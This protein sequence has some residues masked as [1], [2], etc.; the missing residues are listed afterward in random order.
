MQYVGQTRKQLRH[1][2][3]GH[4][5]PNGVLAVHKH[6]MYGDHSFAHFTVQPLE[7]IPDELDDS[8]ADVFLRKR[9]TF[10]IER[11]NTV[12]PNEFNIVLHD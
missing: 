5:N 1:H 10:W 6:Y 8:E 3:R 7:K 9:E 11:L 12:L 2:I 4:L